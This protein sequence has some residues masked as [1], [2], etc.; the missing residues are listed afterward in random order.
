MKRIFTY[1]MICVIALSSLVFSGCSKG[2][3]EAETALKFYFSALKGFNVNAMEE[4]VQ[5]ETAGDIG[6]V[7]EELSDDFRQSD[8]YKKRIEDMMKALSSTFEFTI[9]SN[10]VIDENKVKF[11]VT[12]KC[13]DVNQK[14][15]NE[16]IQE[17]VDKYIIKHPEVYDMDAYEYEETMIG[18][19]ADAYEVFLK[20]QP[21]MTKEFVVTIINVNEKWKVPTVENE[22][23]FDFLQQ[24]Y[25]GEEDAIE[26]EAVED[27][28]A[29]GEETE[30]TVE[31]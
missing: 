16:Y 19:Q 21:R 6:F 5:G 8:N 7:I 10:E 25:A 22:E 13:S 23:F 14:D 17:K 18:V 15:L 31:E 9:N 24:S 20:K 30:E 27:E 3:E 26:L 2:T 28:A 11:D 12:L 4:N 29:E 1:F